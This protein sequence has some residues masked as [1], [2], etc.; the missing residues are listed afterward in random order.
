MLETSP[1][2]ARLEHPVDI[3]E[4]LASGN[5]WTFERQDDDEICMI[6]SGGWTDYNVAFSWLSDME[7]LHVG[8]SFELRPPQRR[9]ADILELIALAN[10]QMWMGHFDLWPS[11]GVVMFRHSLLLAG[12]AQPT[13]AQCEAIL[14][15][16]VAAC[17]R[18]Y[19]AFQFVIWAGKSAREALDSLILETRGE[20]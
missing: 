5:S 7:A 8:C 17:E 11:E 10:E 13:R 6:V 14:S 12:G 16:A 18:Y 20:A 9:R 19:Q 15:H 4:R 1:A 3:V 2:R